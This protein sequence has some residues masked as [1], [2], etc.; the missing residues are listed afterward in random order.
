VSN[1]T[2]GYPD[3]A[4]WRMAMDLTVEVYRLTGDFPGHELY[5]LTSQMRRCAASVPAN[6]A[7]GRGRGG[8]AEFCRFLCIAAG[9]IAELETFL[10]LSRRLGYGTEGDLSRV[11]AQTGEVARMLYGLIN[12]VRQSITR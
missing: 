12:T 7:E 1:R 2:G 9:S 3:L 4:V 8:D 11:R 5:G 10:E 6:V